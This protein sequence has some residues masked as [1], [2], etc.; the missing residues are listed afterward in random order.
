MADQ[1]PLYFSSDPKIGFTA[2]RRA[3]GGMNLTFKDINSETLGHWQK[4]AEEHLIGSDSLVR[5]LYDLRQIDHLSERAV[6]MAV[7][8]NSDPSTRNIR[9]AVVDGND[10]VKA[11]IR[12]VADLTPAG[13]ARMEVFEALDAAEKWLS[14]PLE[15]MA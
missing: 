1:K 13:G 2:E 3:D 10:Q 4:F 15:S 14:R 9:L 12:K 11:A 7:D 8:L 5:N 6:H